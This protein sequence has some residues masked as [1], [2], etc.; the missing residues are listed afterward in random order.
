MPRITEMVSEKFWSPNF[1]QPVDITSTV[2]CLER[3]FTETLG[4]GLW[5][6]T[7]RYSP[8]PTKILLPPPMISDDNGSFRST[9]VSHERTTWGAVGAE[10]CIRA[11]APLTRVRFP[12]GRLGRR[13]SS[14]HMVQLAVPWNRVRVPAPWS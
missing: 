11:S 14:P 13:L 6:R 10:A 2:A 1:W 7:V 3:H 9:V 8:L 5:K 12:G 4:G